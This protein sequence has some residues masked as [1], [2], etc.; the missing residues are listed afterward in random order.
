MS[1]N[2]GNAVEEVSQIS[3]DAWPPIEYTT[4]STTRPAAGAA[5]VVGRHTG[6]RWP[7]GPSTKDNQLL[8]A[9]AVPLLISHK[10]EECLK[11]W[12]DWVQQCGTVLPDRS[13]CDY[14]TSARHS[15]NFCVRRIVD[16]IDAGDGSYESRARSGCRRAG[17][18]LD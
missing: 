5:E 16:R 1:W 10:D 3:G 11:F 2:L 8:S 12:L 18:T 13:R 9:A 7:T 17:I 15:S 6:W 4:R 14:E